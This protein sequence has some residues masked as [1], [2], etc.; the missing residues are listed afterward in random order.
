MR[1]IKGRE[2]DWGAVQLGKHPDLETGDLQTV[3]IKELFI[4]RVIV[5]L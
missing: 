1:A 2:L 3:V 5:D 4:R